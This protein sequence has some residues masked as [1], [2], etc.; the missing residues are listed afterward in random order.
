MVKTLK[1]AQEFEKYV[2]EK[3][4]EFGWDQPYRVIVDTDIK[5][6]EYLMETCDT[7]GKEFTFVVD[8]ERYQMW[9]A[10]RMLIQKAM[11]GIAPEDREILMTHMCGEC[12]KN[13]FGSPNR[14]KEDIPLEERTYR[15]RV[16]KITQT[17]DKET[18]YKSGSYTKY[19]TKD[20]D[21]GFILKKNYVTTEKEKS[22]L[23]RLRRGKS[24]KS[25]QI[26]EPKKG[27]S[28]IGYKI[29]I[30]RTN[31]AKRKNPMPKVGETV[32]T[33]RFMNVTIRESFKSLKEAYQAGYTEPT[34]NREGYE[35]GGY[36]ILGRNISLNHMEFAVARIAKG[37]Y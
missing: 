34:H 30:L 7:C 21:Y 31:S 3:H 1:N 35:E 16:S 25:Y 4:T 14:K 13:M 18:G 20:H 29:K 2:R 10:R 22:K 8:D 5:E 24:M 26:V 23:G 17:R 28:W 36:K 27:S 37:E 15:A 6:P 33:P 11:P 9:K 32:F 19:T 12:W